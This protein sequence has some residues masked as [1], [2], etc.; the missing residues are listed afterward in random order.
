MKNLILTVLL[1]LTTNLIKSQIY[2]L[3]IDTMLYYNYDVKFKTYENALDNDNLERKEMIIIPKKY[4]KTVIVN[5][6]NK[7][8]NYLFTENKKVIQDTAA[9]VRMKQVL[10][11]KL[12]P[13]KHLVLLMFFMKT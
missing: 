10:F 7:T 4:V 13:H 6:N 8:V 2:T 3:T 5:L 11:Y 12:T 9:P 1:I